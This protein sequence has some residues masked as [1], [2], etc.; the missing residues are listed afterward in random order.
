M[1]N[2]VIRA[3][4]HN[5]EASTAF[6][7]ASL[8]EGRTDY[9][10][11]NTVLADQVLR[12]VPG[13]GII[14]A[15][16]RGPQ[17]A[18]PWTQAN[19]EA[20]AALGAPYIP[21]ICVDYKFH[22]P[23]TP[24]DHQFRVA[25]FMSAHRK[26]YVLAEPR[27][28][29]TKSA[30]WAAH[31]LCGIYPGMRVLVVCPRSLLYGTWAA[32]IAT[33]IPWVPHA[34]IYGPSDK[35]KKLVVK[36]HQWHI[37]NPEGVISMQ[38]QLL[39]NRYDIVIVDEST[40]YKNW[41]SDR[42]TALRPVVMNAKFVWPMSGTPV[43]QR[44][45]DAYGQIR[46]LKGKDIDWS[47]SAFETMTMVKLDGHKM[48]PRIGWRDVVFENMQ[49]AIR[50]F[51]RDVL[52]FLPPIVDTYVDVD[53]SSDQK[54]ALRNLR[55]K[56]KSAEVDGTRITAVHEAA[57]RIKLIQVF[58]GSV[59]DKP[60]SEGGRAIEIDAGPRDRV[61]CEL[62]KERLQPGLILEG[63]A[64]GKAMV[65][66]AFRHTMAR[67]SKM[68]TENGLRVATLMGGMNPKVVADTLEKFRRTW[69]TDVLV[70]VP[71]ALAH[72][73][74]ITPAATQ[75]WYTPVDKSEVYQQARERI[76]GP[77]QKLQMEVIHLV[78]DRLE[79]E[80][81]SARTAQR[82]DQRQFMS[83]YSELAAFN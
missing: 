76:D 62:I 51:K 19:V 23:V 72:G 6:A 7:G 30:L 60:E 32:E 74:D 67:V 44:P 69:D 14:G 39:D 63:Q 15:D 4:E 36:D 45:T 17:I 77:R 47:E 52:K 55:G 20:L 13:T 28:G 1:S 73:L 33:S 21:R 71:D 26:G 56:A 57:M 40:L 24:F 5:I 9:F 59:Y 38:R 16:H 81:Y 82:A 18:V 8:I 3:P 10:A 42:W 27:T 25:G 50:V 22:G 64:Y 53:L 66:T 54:M 46:L 35:R 49:P 79:A 2:L 37:I 83:A 48:V 65:M 68:L 70:C 61:L 34:V 75:I 31:Y 43:P 11:V 29:K 12:N 78:S 58:S 41:T 80:I